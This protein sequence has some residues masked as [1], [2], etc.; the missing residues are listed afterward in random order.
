MSHSLEITDIQ[1]L[2]HWKSGLGDVVS[3]D[4]QKWIQ[5]LPMFFSL[6]FFDADT[7]L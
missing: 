5:N 1:T 4:T 6:I 7:Q 3:Q 2:Q